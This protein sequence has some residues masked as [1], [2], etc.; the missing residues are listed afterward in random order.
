MVEL[1]IRKLDSFIFLPFLVGKD[2]IVDG[3]VRLILGL[4]WQ[5]ICHYSTFGERRIAALQRES[6][7][8]DPSGALLTWVNKISTL[9]ITNLTTDWNDGQAIGALVNALAPG[10]SYTVGF[11]NTDWGTQSY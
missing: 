6:Q 10:K 11:P 8:A 2:D 5:M 1:R 7:Q 4:V 9:S 3:N